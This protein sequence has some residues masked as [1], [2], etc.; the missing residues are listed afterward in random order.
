MGQPTFAVADN[1][2]SYKE[3]H[4]HYMTYHFKEPTENEKQKDSKTNC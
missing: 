2:D 1:K 3:S 4:K